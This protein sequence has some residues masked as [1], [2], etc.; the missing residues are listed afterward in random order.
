MIWLLRILLFAYR[1]SNGG[2]VGQWEGH[3]MGVVRM[4][5]GVTDD[6]GP[7]MESMSRAHHHVAC[8]APCAR[9]VERDLPATK[10][11]VR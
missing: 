8:Q 3:A 7:S 10:E 11:R 5:I 6:S 1:L 4:G 9:T 2:A